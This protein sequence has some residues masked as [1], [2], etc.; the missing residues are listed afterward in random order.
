MRNSRFVTS[1]GWILTI[2]FLVC[3]ALGA[4]Q[5]PAA[6]Q[7]PAVTFRAETN[8][9]EVHAI[10]TD[11]TGAFVKGLT[12]DD[13]EI[14]EDGRLQA[15]TV[16]SYIDIPIEKPCTPANASAPIEPDIRATTRNFDGRL[17]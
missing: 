14:Y 7:Q 5:Q 9:V 15:P 8:F 16:F 13:F 1:P 4:A 17:Y 12:K 10:V 3:A 11:K 2:V 6:G